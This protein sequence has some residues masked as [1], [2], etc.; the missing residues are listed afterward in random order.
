MDGATSFDGFGMPGVAVRVIRILASALLIGRSGVR[1]PF[2]SQGGM[3]ERGTK[4]L[5]FGCCRRDSRN[6]LQ[7]RELT[8]K[9]SSR[10][11]HSV[12]VMRQNGLGPHLRKCSRKKFVMRSRKSPYLEL[13]RKV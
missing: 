6:I 7:S 9:F 4:G 13:I 1:C 11:N 3:V 5:C 10:A 2:Y 12:S 8:G